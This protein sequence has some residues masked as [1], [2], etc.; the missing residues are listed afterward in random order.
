[1]NG[2]RIINLTIIFLIIVK[3]HTSSLKERDKEWVEED[4][5]R[6]KIFSLTE[7]H[8]RLSIN[9]SLFQETINLIQPHQHIPL[10]ILLIE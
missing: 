6:L 8:S 5:G 9:L 10:I 7:I 1:M 3:S 2:I 4:Y